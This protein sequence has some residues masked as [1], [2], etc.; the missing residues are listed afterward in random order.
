MAQIGAKLILILEIFW[1]IDINIDSFSSSVTFGMKYK[2]CKF[3]FKIFLKE[4]FLYKKI[5]IENG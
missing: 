4:N 3:F 1:G 5:A 2:N